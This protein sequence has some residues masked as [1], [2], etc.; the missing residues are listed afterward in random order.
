MRQSARLREAEAIPI[1]EYL[2]RRD[3]LYA[4]VRWN[5]A[6]AQ[7]NSGA[8]EA[9]ENT[10]RLHAE[11]QGDGAHTHWSIGLA[12][13]MQGRAES[14]LAQFQDK[15]TDETLRL[16]G[17]VLALTDL[18]RDEE[19]MT[20]LA[21]LKA[22]DAEEVARGLPFLIATA[23]AWTGNLDQ[24]FEFMEEQR[25][26][27]PGWLRVVANSPLY[28]KFEADPRRLPFLER[29]GLAPEQ[30]EAVKFKPRLPREIMLRMEKNRN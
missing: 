30:L 2:T 4:H 25:Q 22:V 26:E 6:R 13:L 11:I 29:A 19:A 27:D 20:A 28:E 3:P 18:G 15:V 23:S 16:H 8:Y 14:A 17:A 12:L 24:A 7:L 21:K 5:L 9:A 1:A 10:Y